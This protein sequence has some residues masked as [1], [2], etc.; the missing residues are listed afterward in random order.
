MSAI[1]YALNEVRNQIPRQLLERAFQIPG[2]TSIVSLDERIESQVICQRVAT[3]INLLGGVELTIPLDQASVEYLN[4][5]SVLFRIPNHL[6]QNR[7]ILQTFNVSFG[8][9]GYYDIAGRSNYSHSGISETTQRLNDATNPKA[10]NFCSDV[11][12][13]NRNTI[14]VHFNWVPSNAL[15]L[16]C[17]VADDD[18]LTSIR[19][20]AYITFSELVTLA[21]KAYIYNQLAIEVDQNAISN[22]QELGV[23]RDLLWD[24]KEADQMYR[25]KRLDWGAIGILQDPEQHRKHI[26]RMIG[27]VW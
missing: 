17:L 1:N 5:Y 9:M 4:N 20:S 27:N 24:Y 10:P 13:I 18:A 6:L 7:R 14:L 26:H 23:F 21:V 25:E 8:P 15:W 11:R 3:D 12:P 19:Q 16:R 22:G 2:T